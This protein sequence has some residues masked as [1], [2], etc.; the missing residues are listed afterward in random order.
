MKDPLN[1]ITF[2][3]KVTFKSFLRKT[4]SPCHPISSFLKIKKN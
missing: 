2:D 1:K 3:T 4:L